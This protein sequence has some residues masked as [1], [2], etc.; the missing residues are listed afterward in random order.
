MQLME[1]SAIIRTAS[2]SPEPLLRVMT[3]LVMTSPI[4]LT[5]LSVIFF[6]FPIFK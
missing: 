2:E 4:L 6:V 3:L 5:I 1:W